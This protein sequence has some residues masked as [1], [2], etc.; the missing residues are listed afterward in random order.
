MS[1]EIHAQ[2][3]RGT[4][5]GHEFHRRAFFY[6]GAYGSH[7][8]RPK[9]E[10][11]S[12]RWT[13]SNRIRKFSLDQLGEKLPL[14]KRRIY[15]RPGCHIPQ[16]AREVEGRWVSEETS[17]HRCWPREDTPAAPWYL[18][19]NETYI[20]QTDRISYGVF[21][22]DPT[23]DMIG[24]ERRKTHGPG[25]FTS[26][27]MARGRSP[28]WLTYESMTYTQGPLALSQTWH[29]YHKLQNGTLARGGEYEA[30][31]LPHELRDIQYSKYHHMKEKNSEIHRLFNRQ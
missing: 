8:L 10:S 21:C 22:F 23:I 9:R 28:D 30:F 31:W 27:D 11:A 1:A 5:A 2:H 15:D 4:R 16:I 6:T 7:I 12:V 24:G 20:I 3:C 17:M 13:C 25:T 26:S 29:S 18:H 14:E 19:G